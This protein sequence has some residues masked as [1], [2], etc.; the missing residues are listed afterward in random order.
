MKHK[1]R[2]GIA[3]SLV[4]ATIAAFV[5]YTLHN[6]SLITQLSKTSI[7]TI[8]SL[9]L[10]Y[11]VWFIII[12]II[13]IVS[14]RLCDKKLGLKENI[15]LNGYSTLFNFF[16]P[17]QGGIAL[18]GIYLKKLK[19]L[20][21]RK[22]IFASLIYY[23][24][25]A[26]ISTGLLLVDNRPWWQTTGALIATAAVSLALIYLYMRRSK[27]KP[28]KLILTANNLLILFGVT[29]IQAF[30]QV[31]IYMVELHSVNSHIT[32]QQAVTY[33]GAANFSLFVA[34]TPGAI[35]IRESFLI[36]SRHLSR[37]SVNNI[38]AASLIDRAV[39]LVFLAFIFVLTIGFH[40]KYRKLLAKPSELTR[41][42]DAA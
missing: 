8:A 33:T 13:L 17:G 40:A 4:I 24:F 19:N 15:L 7:T 38:V 41:A 37:I 36:F 29:L 6:H 18:R 20:S 42:N 14:L 25:Y 30:V 26:I 21:V 22:F 23:M 31:A 32:L 39:F 9:L 5:Y 2:F 3:V 16:I 1:L 28:Y 10:L 35:G 34:L 12:C 11:S 27:A